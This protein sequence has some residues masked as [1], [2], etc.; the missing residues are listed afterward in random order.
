[1]MNRN[2]HRGGR[3]AGITLAVVASTGAA[4]LALTG[5]VSAQ[6]S[7]SGS[8]YHGSGVYRDSIGSSEIS[9]FESWRSRP[10]DVVQTFAAGSTWSDIELP[11]WLTSGW[12][13]TGYQGRLLV[14]IPMLPSSDSSV[15]L[16]AGAT[17]AYNAHWVAAAQHLVAAGEGDAVI[18]PGWELNGGWFLWSAKNDPAAYAAYFRQVVTAMRSVAGQSFRFDWNVNNGSAGWD[19]TRAWPGDGY[20][21]Y[22][23]VDAYDLMWGD[24]TA[25]PQARWSFLVNP[26]GTY[27]QGLQFWDSFAGSHGKQVAFDEWGL[28]NRDAPMANGGGGGDDPYYIQQMYDWV[29]HHN[30]AY[31]AYFDH[32]ASDGT[33]RIDGAT[34]FPQAAA[35]YRQLF[36]GS[37]S[38]GT[39]SSPSPAP[40]SSSP[41]PAPSPTSTVTAPAI[42]LRFSTS[43]SRSNSLTLAGATLV[44]TQYYIFATVSTAASQVVFYVDDPTASGSP[45]HVETWAPWDLAGG[46]TTAA[47]PVKAS[48]L[49]LG[50]HT[51]TVVV[52]TA[53]GT[54]RYSAPF[55]VTSSG[56]KT[57]TTTLGDAAI[58]S[59]LH[60]RR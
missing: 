58:G 36:G 22:V 32:D 33:H 60:I 26:G 51:L 45:Y 30:V 54:Y 53:A 19:A 29:Q 4:A 15:S 34:Q 44:P 23:G 27:P 12:S 14:S 18:R 1:M 59:A 55:T 49:G 11:S 35:T 10:A 6:A 24:S 56:V 25:T 48:S 39:S 28:V 3:R 46:S 38:S 21:D 17:G 5:L 42:G 13:G 40:S 20:V 16:S 31:E 7:A 9:A 47:N 52:T 37:S 57:S 2:P 50:G 8:T 41:A 43:S